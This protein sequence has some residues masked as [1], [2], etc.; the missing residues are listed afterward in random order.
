MFISFVSGLD[1][2]SQRHVT[3]KGNKLRT[4]THTQT[5]TEIL[6]RSFRAIPVRGAN[7]AVDLDLSP[8]AEFKTTF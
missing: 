2:I 8:F 6:L 5:A 1:L 3:G 4:R 7:R